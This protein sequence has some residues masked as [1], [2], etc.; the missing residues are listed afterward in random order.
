MEI[1]CVVDARAATGESPVWDVE[2]QALWWVDIPACKL[3][4]FDPSSGRNETFDM[5]APIGCLALREGRGDMLVALKTGLYTFDPVT[6]GLDAVAPPPFNHRDDRF[7]DGRCDRQGRFWVSAMRD[8]QDPDARSGQFF[9][10]DPGYGLRPMISGL[11]VGNGLAFSPDSRVMY[12]SD[13]HASV[14]TIWAWDYDQTDGSIANRRVFATTRDLGGRPDGAAVDEDGCYWTA[15]NS[16]W[17]LVRLTPQGTVDRTIEL[18]IARP[19]MLAFG[20]RELDVIYV[21][22]MRA[23]PGDPQ[24]DDQPQAGGLFALSVGIK[25]LPEP[26][27]AG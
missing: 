20:G 6:R 27:W 11:I 12:M 22:S 24:G 25:G 16:G 3:H 7:N 21:T 9:R 26:R 13:S 18:P 14:Q 23:Q 8:P 5:P 15:A 19:T 4:R 2:A 17:Q 1:E 10:F